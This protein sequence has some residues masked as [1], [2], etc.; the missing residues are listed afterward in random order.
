MLSKINSFR[1]G[2]SSNCFELQFVRDYRIHIKINDLQKLQFPLNVCPL[3]MNENTSEV[4][5]IPIND[6]SSNLYM[7][8]LLFCICSSCKNIINDPRIGIEPPILGYSKG[9]T[10]RIS[11]FWPISY[12]SNREECT[13]DSSVKIISFSNADYAKLFETKEATKKS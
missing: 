2:S 9:D 13:K 4:L 3:C 11:N 7:G 12:D 8:E 1:I 10:K 6:W 5:I